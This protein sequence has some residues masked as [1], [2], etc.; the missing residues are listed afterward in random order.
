MDTNDLCQALLDHLARELPD[1]RDALLGLAALLTFHPEEV[2][3]FVT[4]AM[5]LLMR[6]GRELPEPLAHEVSGWL[7][8]KAAVA[9]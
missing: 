2:R 6:N 4:E 8:G 7:I 3:L 9:R 5:V 1:E